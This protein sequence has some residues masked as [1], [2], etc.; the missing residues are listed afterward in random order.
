[1]AREGFLEGEA[2]VIVFGSVR[3]RR[4]LANLADPRA[5]SSDE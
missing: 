2:V 3:H 4:T 5:R 1:V